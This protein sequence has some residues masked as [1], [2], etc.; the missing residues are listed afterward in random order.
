MNKLQV[1]KICNELRQV[2]YELKLVQANI[3]EQFDNVYVRLANQGI[4]KLI[5]DELLDETVKYLT[6]MQAR[7][8]EMKNLVD[9]EPKTVR[10]FGAEIDR[11]LWERCPKPNF[12][13]FS[14]IT[15]VSES[16]MSDQEKID[17]PKFFTAGGYLKE[18]PYKQAFKESFEKASK[19][20]RKLI[21]GIPN[22]NKGMFYEI[23]GINIDEY[24]LS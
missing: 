17:N 6:F 16:E 9:E 24:D 14:P 22:F 23:S 11:I 19:E 21:L 15:W 4:T 3:S 1:A 5:V 7:L 2:R 10:V 20:D 12:L 18:I 13:Y 8:N